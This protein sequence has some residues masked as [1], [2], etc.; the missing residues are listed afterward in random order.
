MFC[1]LAI[2]LLLLRYSSRIPISLNIYCRAKLWS[3]IHLETLL[4]ANNSDFSIPWYFLCS[5][6]TFFKML[7]HNI[8]S[9]YLFGK[10]PDEMKLLIQCWKLLLCDFLPSYFFDPFLAYTF[11]QF[12]L[13][14]HYHFSVATIDIAIIYSTIAITVVTITTVTVSAITLFFPHTIT[15]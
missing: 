6:C 11:T 1:N 3:F 9:A 12:I 4:S 2:F 13:V 15:S 14:A 7:G 8:C 10:S 5:K